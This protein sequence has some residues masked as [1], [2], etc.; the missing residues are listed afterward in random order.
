MNEK[1]PIRTMTEEQKSKWINILAIHFKKVRLMPVK[2]NQIAHWIGRLVIEHNNLDNLLTSTMTTLLVDLIAGDKPR[3][4]TEFGEM[5]LAMT[6]ANDIG[7]KDMFMG[8]MSFHQKLD[9]FAAMLLYKF[10]DCSEHKEHIKLVIGQMA[11]A[12][13]FRNKIVHSVLEANQTSYSRVKAGVKGKK[14]LRIERQ[15]FNIEQ[16]KDV[17]IIMQFLQALGFS[18][19]IDEK[20]AADFGDESYQIIKKQFEKYNSNPPQVFQGT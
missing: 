17:I 14:G 15:D 10:A 20:N 12:D 1:E 2:R 9:L 13:A 4:Q 7:L 6:R 16:V 8:A 3:V 18:E 5:S 11:E 19:L